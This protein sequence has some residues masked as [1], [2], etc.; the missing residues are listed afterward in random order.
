MTD[1]ILNFKN[2]FKLK[3]SL[4]K[5]ENNKIVF[6]QND[7]W[8]CS[9]GMNLGEEVFSKGKLFSRPVLIFK[10]FTSNSF[11]GLPLTSRSKSGSWYTRITLSKKGNWVILNQARILDKKRLIDRMGALDDE[12]IKRVKKDFLRLYGS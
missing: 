7:I 4:W 12:D 2:W 1:Y 6:K 9:L 11:L 3:V 8:W 5:F 10:K